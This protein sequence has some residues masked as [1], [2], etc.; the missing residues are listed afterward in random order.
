MN[1]DCA[2]R[3]VRNMPDLMEKI[4][5]VVLMNFEKIQSCILYNMNVPVFRPFICFFV[6]IMRFLRDEY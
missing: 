6:I 2:L 3:F 1:P 5:V 4:C